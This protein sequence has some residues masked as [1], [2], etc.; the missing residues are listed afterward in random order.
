MRSIR[1]GALAVIAWVAAQGIAAP[2]AGE[3][4]SAMGTDAVPKQQRVADGF[5]TLPAS[6]GVTIVPKAPPPEG[7]KAVD[8]EPDPVRT[9]ALLH[10]HGVD[11][12]V[13]DCDGSDSVT[14]E[15]L[16]RC[17]NIALGQFQ[18]SQCPACTA[19]TT[20][21]IPQLIMAVSNSLNGCGGVAPESCPLS[22][23]SASCRDDLPRECP[24]VCGGGCCPSNCARCDP[25]NCLECDNPDIC[26]LEAASPSCPNNAPLACPEACGGG[27]CPSRCQSCDTLN[28]L[29]CN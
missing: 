13:A 17:V 9:G 10:P 22:E 19:G 8:A 16:V 24:A 4:A 20:V 7:P 14:V 23:I 21:A 5:A 26:E 6:A 27:C 1:S 25:T 12:C 28:C 3:A 15:E 11:L 29:E 18:L 2:S